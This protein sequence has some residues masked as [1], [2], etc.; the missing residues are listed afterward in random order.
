MPKDSHSISKTAI[1]YADGAS[2]GNPG[3]A[4][5]GVVVVMDNKKATLSEHIGITTNNVAEYTALIK[6]LEMALSMGAQR[7]KVMLDS[8]LVVKQLKGLYKV[9]NERLQPLYRKTLSL[10]QKFSSSEIQHIP[11]DVNTE[12]DRLSKEGIRL[13]KKDG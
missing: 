7:V 2:S 1:V 8:E 10:L 6:A 13:A 9:K 3:P 12:A 4:G 11:R 5:I